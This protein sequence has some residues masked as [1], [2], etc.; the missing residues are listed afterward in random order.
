M[1]NQWVTCRLIR[2][3]SCKEAFATATAIAVWAAANPAHAAEGEV[4]CASDVSDQ[5]GVTSFVSLLD[6]QP[7]DPKSPTLNLGISHMS[8][9]TVAQPTIQIA[10]G[11]KRGL[12]DAVLSLVLPPLTISN[13]QTS[14]GKVIGASWEQR[15][16][17]DTSHRPTIATFVSASVDY[18]GPSTLTTFQ[19]TAIV[20]KTLDQTVLYANAGLSTTIGRGAPGGVVPFLTLGVKWPARADNAFVADLVMIRDAPATFEL[21]YQFSGPFDFDIG[22]GFSVTLERKPRVGIGVVIQ[23]EF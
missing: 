18:S 3:R 7:T 20:A 23:R 4:D 10:P 21:G 1:R 5:Q 17:E 12:C 13:G 16:Q 6:G 15:W 19:A 8:G 9:V 2:I 22:P 14:I 11:S